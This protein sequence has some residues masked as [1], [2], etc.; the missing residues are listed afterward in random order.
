MFR[1][2]RYLISA[3]TGVLLVTAAVAAGPA[4]T[5]TSVNEP[6]NVLF[7]GNSFTYYNNSLHNHLRNMM[8]EGGKQ[9]GTIR[10]MTIS[11][12]RL[13]QHAPAIRAQLAA[14]DWDIV[15]LQGQ[16]TE[17]IDENRVGDFRDAVHAYAKAIKE[18]GAEPVLFMTWAPGDHPEHTETLDSS[19]TSI[20]N[21]T[22]SLVVPAGLAFARSDELKTGIEMRVADRRHPTPAG[23]Y[24]A[25][26]TFYAALFGQSP[27]GHP[28]TGGLDSEHAETLQ[29]IAWDTVQEYYA[30][31]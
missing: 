16:S 8:R 30:R 15:I 12:A 18:A 19:Y 24:L 26:C 25:A 13:K 6:S 3:A 14:N 10:S 28:Y 1:A 7:V 31:R 29:Q 5:V 20:G 9:V 23:S 27:V 22:G 17:A 4:P 2:I 11:G 21:E